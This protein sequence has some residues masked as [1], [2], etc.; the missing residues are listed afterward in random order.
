MR[1]HPQDS[2]DTLLKERAQERASFMKQRVADSTGT[3]AAKL[4]TNVWSV[5]LPKVY[6]EGSPLTHGIFE[7]VMFVS[8]TETEARKVARIITGLPQEALERP[9]WKVTKGV[10]EEYVID[11]KKF[12]ANTITR[13]K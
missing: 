9:N 7:H 12:L 2:T 13:E 5:K 8:G 10:G 11:A 1:I 4:P 3:I 6:C